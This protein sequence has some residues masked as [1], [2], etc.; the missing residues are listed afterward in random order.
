MTGIEMKE[1]MLASRAAAFHGKRYW[2]NTP[3]DGRREI[4]VLQGLGGDI[5][6]VG[7]F[8]ESGARRAVKSPSIR[9][10]ANPDVLQH[11]LNL[12]AK[13]RHFEEVT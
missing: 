2:Y 3:A 7:Y 8:R 6:I 9:A 13:A 5:W 10:N 12:W 1:K 11:A 4:G